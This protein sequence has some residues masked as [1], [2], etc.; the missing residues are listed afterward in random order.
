MAQVKARRA[1]RSRATGTTRR[2]A[3]MTVP[4]TMAEE[5]ATNPFMRAHSPE[6]AR[7]RAQAAPRHAD[8]S[9][10]RARCRARAEGQI[11]SER[12]SLSRAL[13]LAVAR[14]A[15]ARPRSSSFRPEDRVTLTHVDDRVI[16]VIGGRA[17]PRS[18][19]KLELGESVVALRNQGNVAV[20]VTSRRLL[21]T[22]SRDANFVE[23][24]YRVSETAAG[25]ARPAGARP[26][27]RRGVSGAHRRLLAAD[28]RAGRNSASARARSR[29][30]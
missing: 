1:R 30:R 22:Q 12:C 24:R 16:A 6:L 8:R 21:A 26:A 27:D 23:L 10:Q 29:S 14:A 2:E 9:D 28:R 3:E 20:A 11:L 13:L 7:E 25:R 5:R 4:S 18:I 19:A 15:S 17:S